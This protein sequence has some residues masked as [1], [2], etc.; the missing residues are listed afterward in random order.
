MRNDQ[1][2]S[3]QAIRALVAQELRYGSAVH[4]DLTKGEVLNEASRWAQMR[5]LDADLGERVSGY[6]AAKVAAGDEGADCKVCADSSALPSGRIHWLTKGESEAL[7]QRAADRP[8]DHSPA[9][10]GR[11]LHG[12]QDY[13]AHRGQG[14]T[15]AASM[16]GAVQYLAGVIFGGESLSPLAFWR[17]LD[18]GHGVGSG[19]YW[20]GFLDNPD[21]YDADDPRF[22]AVR[23][24]TAEY[25][26][27]YVAAYLDWLWALSEADLLAQYAA[28]S[29]ELTLWYL[30]HSPQPEQ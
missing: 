18:Y 8:Q 25:V 30:L 12:V 4:T 14:Y 9:A 10:F 22:D 1:I 11:V 13:Y 26:D 20:L 7:A 3:P 6:V 16:S 23:A 28:D 5:G 15:L 2:R 29:D 19:L 21:S 27:A 17:S 24:A